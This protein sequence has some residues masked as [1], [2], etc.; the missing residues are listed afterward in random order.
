MPVFFLQLRRDE[1]KKG[2]FAESGVSCLPQFRNFTTDRMSDGGRPY[3]CLR[4]TP[5]SL[6]CIGGVSI[7]LVITWISR[8]L[9]LVSRCFP[10]DICFMRLQSDT[11]KRPP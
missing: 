6:G 2:R 5:R 7:V 8:V 9:S 11:P 4:S 3:S 1:R 10:L